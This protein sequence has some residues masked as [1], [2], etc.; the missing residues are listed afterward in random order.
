MTNPLQNLLHTAMLSLSL[1][2]LCATAQA[3]LPQIYP[4]PQQMHLQESYTRVSTVKILNATESPAPL[5]DKEGA[6]AIQISGDTL[7][8]YSKDAAGIFYAKQSIIQLL[9]GVDESLAAQQDPFEG[10]ELTDIVKLGELP[11]GTIVDW[12]DL[13]YRGSV[14]GYYGQ[15]WSH[16][17]RISQLKFY[18][19]NKLNTYI[20]AAKDDPYHHGYRCREP[21][22]ADVAKQIRELCQVAKQNHVKFVWA[23]H[24]ANTV[25]WD[26]NGGKTDLDSLCAK[27][28]Q[29]YQL[30]V[31]DFGVFV[32]D[33]SG[34]INKASRQGQLCT[35]IHDNFIKKHQDVGPLIMCPTGYN[36]AWTNPAWMG[37]LGRSLADDIRVMWT[38]NTVVHDIKLEG[39]EWV[40]SALGRPT[41]IWWNWP[42]TDF[43]RSHVGMGRTYGLDQ[44]PEM[45]NLMSGFVANPMEWPEA[46]KIALFGVADYTWNI[47][48]FESVRNWQDG[49]KRLFPSCADAVQHF[50]NNNSDLGINTHRYRREESVA[51]ADDVQAVSEGL[52]EGQL[53]EGATAR[54]IAEC[55][56]A[57]LAS[58]KLH[59]NAAISVLREE[60]G[61]WFD[62]YGQ[63]GQLGVSSLSIIKDGPN[64]EELDVLLHAWHWYEAFGDSKKKPKVATLC[65]APMIRQA[66]SVATNQCYAK[67]TGSK[68]FSYH[69]TQF[70]CSSWDA[71][72]NC[73]K[74]FDNNPATFWSQDCNQK[75]GDWYGLD[76]G[77]PTDIKEINL[78]MGGYRPEDYISKGQF[79][80][81]M[82]GENWTKV[83]Q[84]Q[85]TDKIHLTFQKPIKAKYL[86]YRIIEAR[87]NW[88]TICEFN[89]EDKTPHI[90]HSSVE[91]WQ[92]AIALRNEKYVGIRRIMEVAHMEPN[93]SVTLSVKTPVNA[94][95]LEVN[96][97]NPSIHQWAEVYVTLDNGDK[98]RIHF[99]KSQQSNTLVARG[100]ALPKQAIRSMT[101]INKGTETQDVKLNMFKMDCPPDDNRNIIENMTDGDLLSSWNASEMQHHFFRAPEGSKAAVIIGTGLNQIAVKQYPN[102]P[103]RKSYQ[104]IVKLEE[105]TKGITLER[106]PNP[107]GETIRPIYIHEVIFVD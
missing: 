73:E 104:I 19:R 82:D 17:A 94:T 12:P 23:I 54:I 107:E 7:R 102:A 30:G 96:F 38:G 72:S 67:I 63:L 84:T 93:Q 16:A 48:A 41:F 32:D 92:N 31:R 18:G 83:G 11:Q 2:G 45:K 98:Q 47:E 77:T 53:P 106:K 76:F 26:D 89:I 91:G 1:A 20:W 78:I 27:L 70:I 57:I 75:A 36:R 64:I 22:P 33:S 46:S 28:E 105:N 15:P 42:C 3:A 88:L 4:H 49:I 86:R 37:E 51:I 21:Y 59:N 39:Q 9:Q 58:Q 6:Y 56:G 100:N 97:D 90:V 60:V 13:P 43:C 24:P 87:N 14:E 81:S 69:G 103:C 55:Q 44:S 99:S 62:M 95:W 29:M 74:I 66:V 85:S 50:C 52:K 80:Y 71:E 8:I 25:N 65:L 40:K 5:P 61:E 101:L 79:E 68:N 10:R 35:Y 34:E